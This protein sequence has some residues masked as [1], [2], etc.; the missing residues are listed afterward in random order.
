MPVRLKSAGPLF[1]KVTLAQPGFV[2]CFHG[3]GSGDALLSDVEGGPL[4]RVW[5]L[6]VPFS[7]PPGEGGVSQVPRVWGE[8][9]T[10]LPGGDA[11]K[12][13]KH[14]VSSFHS[15]QCPGDS[16][17]KQ[18]LT[19]WLTNNGF[20]THHYVYLCPWGFTGRKG[21]VCVCLGT[22]WAEMFIDVRVR[23][24]VWG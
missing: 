22:L 24:S 13:C 14:L 15:S 4:C 1:C 5:E 9:D 10:A 3:L 23:V 7:L 16:G 19:P 2:S 20:L 17:L 21:R 6:L 8:C 18:C 12:R 11:L